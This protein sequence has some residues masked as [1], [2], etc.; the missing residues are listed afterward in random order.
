VTLKNEETLVLCGSDP[1]GDPGW[2][3]R[4]WRKSGDGRGNTSEQEEKP[5]INRRLLLVERTR[6]FRL[7]SWLSPARTSEPVLKNHIYTLGTELR[8]NSGETTKA[9][10][11]KKK[12]LRKYLG[13]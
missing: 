6:M 10:G 5:L 3:L 13:T 7:L 2:H 12:Y 9:Y 11:R 4:G 8:P 1:W